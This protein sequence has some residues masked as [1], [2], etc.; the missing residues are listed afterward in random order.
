[1]SKSQL[2]QQMP[3]YLL[4]WNP[5]NWQWHNLADIARQL[6]EGGSIEQR[7]SCGHSRSIAVGSRVFL[8]RQGVEPKGIVA[9]GWVTKT[10]F[11]DLHWDALR[12]AKGEQTFFVMFVVDALLNPDVSPPLDVRAITAGPLADLQVNA[13]ASGNS[14]PELVA[15]ALSDAWAAHLSTHLNTM[16]A[17]NIR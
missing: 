11:A 1:M 8:L 10:P 15:E 4:T 7:W 9:S 16:R 12:A 2:A 5:K 13:R 17:G 14:I 6:G 3:T